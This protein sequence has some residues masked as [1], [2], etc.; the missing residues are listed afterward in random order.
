MRGGKVAMALA[1]SNSQKPTT[2]LSHLVVVDIAPVNDALSPD[3]VRYITAMESV[4]DMPHT[5]KTH[6]DADK[7]LKGYE[8]V[9]ITVLISRTLCLNFALGFN[10]S[11]ISLDKSRNP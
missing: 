5:I 1:L 6:D 8:E 9:G 4:N 11:S 10:Y 3:F 2:P 7:V